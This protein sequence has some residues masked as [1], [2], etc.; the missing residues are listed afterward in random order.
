MAKMLR[1]ETIAAQAAGSGDQTTGGIVPAIHVAST[2][3]RDTDNH[4]RKGFCYGRSDNLTVRQTEDVLTQ[5]EGGAVTLLYASGMTA[6]TTAFLALER[7]A[8]VIAPKVMYW[9]LRQWL[10]EDAV[11]LGIETSFVDAGDPDAIRDAIRPGRT[12]LIWIETPSNPLWTITDIAATARIARD[13]GA[14]LA[15]DSTVSTPV[16]TQPLRLGA[17]MVLHSA[18]KY[19][20]GHSDVVAGAT[21]FARH[22]DAYDRAARLRNTLG[23]ILGPFEA[24]L[25]MRGM[26]TLHVRVRHQC[27]SAMSIARH[28]VGHEMIKTVLYPGL[29]THCGHPL[30][31]SQMQGGFGGMLSLRFRHGE[32]AAIACAANLKLW[33]RAT[34]LG[35]VESLVEHRASIEGRGSPCPADLLRLSVGLENVEDLIEDLEAAL[36]RCP[37]VAKTA[38]NGQ[39]PQ[40]LNGHLA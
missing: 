12:K 26:R 27:A 11:G 16:L 35:G 23:G 5:L 38:L 4:Y 2:F 39:V 15:V 1:P 13:G 29:E 30:A 19:L 6:A 9:G 40:H 10:A 32:V 21:V 20:N 34:S 8:H 17:D 14:L 22:G 24:S 31:A 37:R 7:P 33:K 28:F 36:M 18:T 25:L 3:V